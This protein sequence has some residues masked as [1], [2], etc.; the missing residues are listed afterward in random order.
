[1]IHIDNYS[2]AVKYFSEISALGSVPGLDSTIALLESSG[3]PEFSLPIIHI[4]GTNGKGSTAS[5]ISNILMAQGYVVGTFISPWKNEIK[6]TIQVNGVNISNADFT[7]YTEKI[8]NFRDDIFNLKHLIATEFETAFVMS[9]LY[10]K[11][12]RCDYV[13]IEVGMGGRIDATNAVE[14]TLISVITE[15]SYDH[16]NYLGNDL[17]CIA[18]EKCGIIKCGGIVVSYPNQSN[19]VL[20]AI[21]LT[22]DAMAAKTIYAD[23][24]LLKIKNESIEETLFDYGNFH[25]LA[26]HLP[27]RHQVLNAITAIETALALSKYLNVYCSDEAISSGLMSTGFKGRLEIID[28]SPTTIFDVAHN[29]SGISALASTMKLYFPDKKIIIIMGVL[30][31]KEYEKCVEELSKISDIFI[32]VTPD[33]LRALNSEKLVT[34]AKRYFRESIDMNNTFEAEC[35]AKSIADENTIICICGSHYN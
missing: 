20:E 28:D 6:E 18:Y 34:V 4:A 17:T 12:I 32:G 1:V 11:D 27:G 31:D 5:F 22:S 33:N 16:M 10:F 9:L 13:V 23:S 25:N 14:R 21:E 15:I 35:Y 24:S 29:F 2:A 3:H 26:I 19:E 8:A 7:V 30:A